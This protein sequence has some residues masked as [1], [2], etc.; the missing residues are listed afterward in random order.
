MH[1]K[2][3]S[4]D[5]QSKR[6]SQRRARVSAADR[7]T[8]RS[9][10]QRKIAVQLVINGSERLVKGVGSFGLDAKLGGVLR[11]ECTDANGSFDLLIREND[12]NGQIKPGTPFGCD[13]FVY[14]SLSAK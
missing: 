3:A 5:P 7:L 12:W 1:S 2:M 4:S 8:L 14:L 9:L 6:K 11:I 13:Y 10:D